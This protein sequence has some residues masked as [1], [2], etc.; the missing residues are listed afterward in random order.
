MHN[1]RLLQRISSAG[2]AAAITFACGFSLA[3]PAPVDNDTAEPSYANERASSLPL[4]FEENKGQ[5]DPSVRFVNRSGRST[6]FLRDGDIV[7]RLGTSEPK[8]GGAA[9]VQMQFVGASDGAKLQGSEQFESKSSYFRGSDPD[10][11]IT[12]VEH[13]GT[14]TYSDI[15]PGIDVV[16]HGHE[17]ALRYDFHIAPQVDPGQI[18]LGF[19]GVERL[20]VGEDGN[21][22]LTTSAGDVTHRAPVIYQDIDGERIFVRGTFDIENEDEVLFALADYDDK[23]T[24]VIDPVIS[25]STYLGGSGNDSGRAVRVNPL[26]QTIVVTGQTDS[27]DFPTALALQS[28]HGSG[29]GVDPSGW[30]Q[31]PNATDATFLW[32]QTFGRTDNYSAKITTSSRAVPLSNPG[33]KTTNPVFIDMSKSHIASYFAYSGLSFRPVPGNT[34][35]PRHFTSHTSKTVAMAFWALTFPSGETTRV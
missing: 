8:S 6:T 28:T 9:V 17:G 27:L 14:V 29:G 3:N 24:L 34:G 2:C 30:S 12:G 16:F 11:W 22:I 1:T 13:F 5:T 10:S 35:K 25:Y 26:D 4:Y 18:Q 31:N 19:K 21:L 15:Y 32:D 20:A 7:M 23:Y 33:W